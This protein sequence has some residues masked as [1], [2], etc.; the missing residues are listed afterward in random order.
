M[1]TLAPLPSEESPESESSSASKV[2]LAD[3]QWQSL[4]GMSI[5]E[6]HQLQWE[7]EQLFAGAIVQTPKASEERSRV[8]AQAYDTICTILSAQQA[9][10]EPLV[11]GMDA[12]YVKLVLELLDRQVKQGLGHPGFFEIGYG[13]GAMLKPKEGDCCVFCSYADVHCPSMQRE[14]AH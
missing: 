7:Q 4:E 3:G 10:D 9:G 11:M 12:R 5:R 1:L 14:A 6:L 2:M 13:C 8:T